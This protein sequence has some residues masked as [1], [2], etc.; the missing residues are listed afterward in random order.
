MLANQKLKEYYVYKTN[1]NDKV[2][3]FRSIS[4]RLALTGLKTQ[5]QAAFFPCL[6]TMTRIVE[7][8]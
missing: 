5:F 4:Y 8:N 7:L 2:T 1:S 3:I 6:V